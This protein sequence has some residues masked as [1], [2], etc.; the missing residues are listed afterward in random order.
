MEHLVRFIVADDQVRPL[1]FCSSTLSHISKSV[2]VVECP[3]FRQLCMLLRESLEE[4]DIPRRDKMREIIVS[5]WRKS[6]EGLKLELSVS[7]IF[8]FPLY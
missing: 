7:R 8:V 1:V 3:E 2:R 6:F 4:A 5:H